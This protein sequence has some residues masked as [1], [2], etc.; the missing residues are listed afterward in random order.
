MNVMK[1]AKQLMKVSTEQVIEILL[2][3]GTKKKK[4]KRKRK[5]K[6]KER[7]K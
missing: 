4:K 6:R 2:I 3:D 1:M 7:E 5:K